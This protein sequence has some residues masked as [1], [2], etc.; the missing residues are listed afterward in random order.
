[1][2]TA[3]AKKIAAKRARRPVYGTIVRVAV[4]ET[5][6]E[7]LAILASHPIDRKLMKERKFREGDELR[8]EIKRPR[9]VKFHRLMHAVGQVMVDNVDGWESLDAHGAVKR[10]QRESGVC[11]E[12]VE[13]DIPGMG[14]L[15]AKQAESL[16]F[17]EMQPDRFAELFDGIT[18]HIDANYSPDFT[19]EVRGEYLLMV[20][21][22]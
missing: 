19:T 8:L 16:S 14:T 15:L 1:M 2:T 20:A 11:C 17:D 12:E 4:L 7:R 13:I 21:G 10:L 22:E 5:G 6:E 9:N 18:K 3:A